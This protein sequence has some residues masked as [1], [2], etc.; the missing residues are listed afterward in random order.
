[1]LV[2]EVQK[3]KEHFLLDEEPLYQSLW[4]PYQQPLLDVNLWYGVVVV[5]V[6]EDSGNW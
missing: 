6:V 2:I 4:L 5:M 3:R 1:M